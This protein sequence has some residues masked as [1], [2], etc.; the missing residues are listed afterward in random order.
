MDGLST[1]SYGSR[2]ID[3]YYIRLLSSRPLNL[4]ISSMC[5][6]NDGIED[7]EHSFCDYAIPSRKIVEISP[8]VNSILKAHG[9]PDG[10]N[11]NI[12]QILL[13]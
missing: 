11:D 8:P 4:V 7:A 10:L 6:A 9:K 1:I 2:S 12:L 5:P 3:Y 13:Y